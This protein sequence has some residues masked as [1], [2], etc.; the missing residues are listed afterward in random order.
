MVLVDQHRAHA[1]DEVRAAD[2]LGGGRQLEP[3]AGGE[4]EL[5]PLVDLGRIATGARCLS[6]VELSLWIIRNLAGEEAAARVHESV[7]PLP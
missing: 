7:R 3:E 6:G 4:V 2:Q 5:A 1:L